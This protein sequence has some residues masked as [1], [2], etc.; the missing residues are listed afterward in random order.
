MVAQPKKVAGRWRQD[1]PRIMRDHHPPFAMEECLGKRRRLVN[2]DNEQSSRLENTRSERA[3][4]LDQN[5]TRRDFL[6]ST[7]LASGGMLLSPLSPA[8]L[9]AQKGKQPPD[10]VSDDWTGY[11]GVGDYADSNGNTTAVF[12]AGHR[13]RDGEFEGLPQNLLETGEVY[14]CVVV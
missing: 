3:L 7:L 13:I 8:Q 14:D 2:Q 10:S 12:E 9:L 6:N 11:G 1:S 5:I 4:G